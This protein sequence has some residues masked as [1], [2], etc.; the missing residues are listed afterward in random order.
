VKR[1]GLLLSG[2]VWQILWV[3]WVLYFAVV[4]GLGI[5]SKTHDATFSANTRIWFHTTTPVGRYGF[6]ILLGCFAAW[7]GPHIVR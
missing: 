1:G 3:V 5:R 4:E 6:L 2:H 7:F